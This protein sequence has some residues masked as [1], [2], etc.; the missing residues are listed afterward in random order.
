MS[1]K[2]STSIRVMRYWRLWLAVAVLV[3]LFA[4][5]LAVQHH[6]DSRLHRQDPSVL[7]FERLLEVIRD[8]S[9][10]WCTEQHGHSGLFHMYSCRGAPRRWLRE[11]VERPVQ[12]VGGVCPE[13]LRSAEPDL[14]S[15]AA[16][17]IGTH[18]IRDL[19][20]PLIRALKEQEGLESRPLRSLAFGLGKIGLPQDFDLLLPYAAVPDSQVWQALWR[21]DSSRALEEF[22]RISQDNGLWEAL[23]DNLAVE[24]APPLSWALD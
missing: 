10:S 7:S 3:G 22:E 4:T 8:D 14:V 6:L 23:R 9:L 16:E 2:S 12:R 17:F 24:P 20:V 19:R 11:L 21:L 13:F 18:Q 15:F 1:P 5:S